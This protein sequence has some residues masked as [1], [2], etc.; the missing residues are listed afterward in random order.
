MNLSGFRQ[1]VDILI[2]FGNLNLKFSKNFKLSK[3]FLKLKNFKMTIQKI[4]KLTKSCITNRFL[5]S[6]IVRKSCP[7]PGRNGAGAGVAAETSEPEA[8][9]FGP[10]PYPCCKGGARRMNPPKG[11]GFGTAVDQNISS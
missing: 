6:C 8:P 9:N 2:F 11:G 1:A 4:R 5:T 3:A 7:F 10:A